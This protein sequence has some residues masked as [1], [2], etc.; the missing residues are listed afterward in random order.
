MIQVT[1][2]NKFIITGNDL[3]KEA[4]RISI[5]LLELTRK[6][7]E[8]SPQE[9]LAFLRVIHSMANGLA[10]PIVE[11]EDKKAEV[12]LKQKMAE[13]RRAKKKKIGEFKE[14]EGA[15]R[16]EGE[17]V[18]SEVIR[19]GE[20]LDGNTEQFDTSS[21]DATNSGEFDSIRSDKS[22]T[23]SGKES[24]NSTEKEVVSK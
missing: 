3:V 9:A 24:G 4:S 16:T 21:G 10:R 1:N 2:D 18:S 17:A 22:A 13:K 11:A 14:T 5:A 19:K 6:L 7:N 8:E 23:E 15:D 20:Q 12:S